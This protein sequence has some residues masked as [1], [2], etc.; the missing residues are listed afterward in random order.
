MNE[1]FNRDYRVPISESFCCDGHCCLLTSKSLGGSN[2]TAVQLS[3]VMLSGDNARVAALLAAG[4]CLPVCFP[5]D[6][7]LDEKTIFL[8]GELSEPEEKNWI[9]RLAWKLKIPC[10]RL[11]LCCGCFA[12]DLEPALSDDPEAG[13]YGQFQIVEIPPGDYL[14]E[15]YAYL[16]SVTVK[17]GLHRYTRTGDYIEDAEKR[18]WYERNRPGLPDLGYLIRLKPLEAPPPLPELNEGWFEKFEFRD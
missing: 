1:N 11:I 7:A 4:V 12:E 17:L 16:E 10:G 8:V 15:I 5:G 9:A 3:D 13:N 18:R 6:C 14:V 2:Y